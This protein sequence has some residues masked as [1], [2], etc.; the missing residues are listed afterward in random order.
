MM[1]VMM[2]VRVRVRVRMRVNE[3]VSVS[4][5]VSVRARV[6]AMAVSDHSWYQGKWDQGWGYPT[7]S[8]HQD[9]ARLLL[10]LPHNTLLPLLP[11]TTHHTPD[12]IDTV[13]RDQKQRT[14]HIRL[15]G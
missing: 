11:H 12:A 7:W 15:P 1:R 14:H 9:P 13:T 10:L 3:S 6:R 2:R 8:A 5:S 4:V